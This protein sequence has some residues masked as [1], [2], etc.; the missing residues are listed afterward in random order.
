MIGAIALV[1]TVL[2]VGAFSSALSSTTESI[3]VQALDCTAP[4]G[5]VCVAPDRE[6]DNVC[7][8]AKRFNIPVETAEELNVFANTCS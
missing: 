7:D 3:M 6:R 2:S 8:T 1:V 4:E 5:F